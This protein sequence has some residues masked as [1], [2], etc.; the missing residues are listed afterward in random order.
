MFASAFPVSRTVPSTGRHARNSYRTGACMHAQP[1]QQVAA[2]MPE[3]LLDKLPPGKRGDPPPSQE[4]E[5]T[6]SAQTRSSIC[7]L[8]I[9]N[10]RSFRSPDKLSG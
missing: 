5:H 7:L 8:V 6:Q 3:G 4:A 9:S 10:I 1:S 2:R